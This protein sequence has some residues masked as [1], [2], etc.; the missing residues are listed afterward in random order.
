MSYFFHM[1]CYL[2]LAL[3]I[4]LIVHKQI[5]QYWQTDWGDSL[6]GK[7]LPYRHDDL[8]SVPRNQVTVWVQSHGLVLQALGTGD[9]WTSLPHF[10]AKLPYLAYLRTL[11]QSKGWWVLG[12]DTHSHPMASI[13]LC[14]QV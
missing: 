10:S 8:Q 6:A 4:S 2:H 12:K 11:F 7:L 5:L 3:V 14:N 9:R 13:Q 1:N